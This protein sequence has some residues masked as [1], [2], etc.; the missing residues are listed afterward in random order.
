MNFKFAG[1]NHVL[2]LL[3]EMKSAGRFPH[4]VIFQGEKGT[5]K[6]TLARMMAA[7]L[8]CTA[9]NAPCG[10]CA[11]CKRAAAGSHPDI[12]IEEGSG[13]TRS[14][15]VE[16]ARRIILDA[17]RMPEE[18]D[19]NIYLLF[20]ENKM[21]EITQNKLLKLIEEPPGNTVFI[22]TIPSAESLLPTIRSRSQIFTLRPP[23]IEEAVD[24]VVSTGM[25]RAEAESFAEACG[26]NIGKMLEEKEEGEEGA[27]VIAE[28]IAFAAAKKDAQ[29]L[30]EVTALLSRNRQLIGEVLEK[31]AVI[32]RDG[33]VLRA[34]GNE[35]LSSSK[36]AA[37]ELANRSA[38]DLLFLTDSIAEWKRKLDRNANMSL[39]ITSM[40]MEMA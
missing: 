17:Y 26:G 14:L 12:R 28:R 31:L 34:G 22:I 36:E 5:G 11:A 24:Y 18:A 29:R 30:L 10:E 25:E 15:N 7:A 38:A 40:C 4:A 19:Y 16:A 37:K 35:I 33:C 3:S 6:K 27:S 13:A 9:E 8:V 23:A 21:P 1:N 32:F 2:T 20:V 39:L